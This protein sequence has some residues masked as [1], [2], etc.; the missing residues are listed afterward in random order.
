MLSIV[1]AK[2]GGTINTDPKKNRID[3]GSAVSFDLVDNISAV[4]C[5]SNKGTSSYFVPRR[6]QKAFNTFLAAAPRLDSITITEDTCIPHVKSFL[7]S[8]DTIHELADVSLGQHQ[9]ATITARLNKIHNSNVKLKLQVQ[10]TAIYSPEYVEPGFTNYDYTMPL[11]I[12]IPAGSIEGS[13]TVTAIHNLIDEADES[14]HITITSVE[15]AE[16]RF[17]DIQTLITIV[18]SD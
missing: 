10:G 18:N 8:R 15:N 16:N 6:T 4:Y 11:E 3:H 17:P 13:I 2:H 9:S 14:I 5:V 12:V 1:E 7:I